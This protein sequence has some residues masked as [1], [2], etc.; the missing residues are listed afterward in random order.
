M[1]NLAEQLERMFVF[2]QVLVLCFFGSVLMKHLLVKTKDDNRDIGVGSHLPLTLSLSKYKGHPT[3]DN[4]Y[5]DWKQLPAIS[6]KTAQKLLNDKAIKKLIKDISDKG[7]LPSP[8]DVGQALLNSKAIK[9]LMGN[10]DG[11]GND[12]VDWK[13][14]WD[15][16]KNA[17]SKLLEDEE[18]KKLIKDS[19][20][21]GELPSIGDVGQ[22]FLDSEAFKEL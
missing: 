4:D 15:S 12:Y 10:G 1:G 2:R 21:K 22:A 14:V 18:L 8:G 6:G 13:G 7:E 11:K 19:V 3:D 16:V 5:F 17:G 9:D 20:D